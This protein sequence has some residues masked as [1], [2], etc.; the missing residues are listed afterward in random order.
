MRVRLELW[1]GPY[2][3]RFDAQRSRTQPRTGA[4]QV[5]VLC[6][7]ESAFSLQALTLRWQ[8]SPHR[9]TRYTSESSPGA[10]PVEEPS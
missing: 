3:G 8:A 4:C 5:G 9:G 1:H 6:W 7:A 10:W 2:S